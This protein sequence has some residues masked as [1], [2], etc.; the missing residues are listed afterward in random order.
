MPF[1]F[2]HP[3]IIL[4]LRYLPKSWFSLTGLIIGSL[5]PDF[6]YFL[7]MKVKSNY[8]HTLGGI[9]WFD[10]PFA[11]L[12]TFVFHNLIRNC[13]FQNLPSAIK[14]R[15]LVFSTFNWNIYFQKN[16]LIVL[17]SL[18]V[19]IISHI[20]WDGFTHEHGY[21]V[22]QI[23]FFRNTFTIFGKEIPLWKF[24]QHGSTIIGAI[25]IIIAFL[26][27]PQN[28]NFNVDIEK[29][30]WITVLLFTSAILFIRF[31]A[32]PKASN[33]GN[34]VVSFIAALLISMTIIPFLIKFQLGN[35]N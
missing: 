17:I 34:F 7:R 4:P 16:W 31:I 1:T 14:K 8:S 22:N 12:L 6:E 23:E 25:I 29:S 28:F 18:F 30:Y 5:T 27:L 13:L 2:S 35:K 19:G 15:I 10:L 9:F 33:I 32:N 26:K 3:A 24:L 20:L 11:L 21:F